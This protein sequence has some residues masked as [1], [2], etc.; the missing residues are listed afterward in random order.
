MNEPRC[1]AKVGTGGQAA[2]G[3]R[4]NA[5]Y[6]DEPG[7]G[8]GH[9]AELVDVPL[10]VFP[11]P[12][13]LPHALLQSLDD[14]DHPMQWDADESLIVGKARQ[15]ARPGIQERTSPDPLPR[16]LG[17]LT[18][19]L[20]RREQAG[21]NDVDFGTSSTRRPAPGRVERLVRWP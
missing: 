10:G 15:P 8:R 17:Q 19:K 21:A 16:R 13:R 14:A 6:S 7:S 1:R 20:T 9:L 11:V 18:T 3:T 5:A 2:C 12:P 4:R